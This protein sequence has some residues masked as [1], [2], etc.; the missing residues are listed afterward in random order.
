LPQLDNATHCYTRR[1]DDSFASLKKFYRRHGNGPPR[2]LCSKRACFSIMS[3]CTDRKRRSEETGL[4]ATRRFYLQKRQR[5]RFP[6]SPTTR[7]SLSRLL[8][9]R[10]SSKIKCKNKLR[11]YRLS[12]CLLKDA[13]HVICTRQRQSI[14]QENTS[15]LPHLLHSLSGK[16]TTRQVYKEL[17]V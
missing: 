12:A 6:K 7:R 2:S 17:S 13:A 3:F 16:F 5:W 10:C 1:P 8:I 14:L 11:R 9:S 4:D 15:T